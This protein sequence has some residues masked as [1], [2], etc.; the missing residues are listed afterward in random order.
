MAAPRVITRAPTAPVLTD[1][2]RERLSQPLDDERE[3]VLTNLARRSRTVSPLV[4]GAAFFSLLAAAERPVRADDVTLKNGTVMQNVLVVETPD[5]PHTL[6]V[7]TAPAAW[8]EYNKDDVE[9][10]DKKPAILASKQVTVP[11]G[12]ATIETTK[13]GADLSFP[14]QAEAKLP[15]DAVV[16]VPDAGGAVTLTGKASVRVPADS[17]VGLPKG[18]S[19]Q[20]ANGVVADLPADATVPMGPQDTA[21][22][23]PTDKPATVTF[24]GKGNVTTEAGGTVTVPANAGVKVPG[25]ARVSLPESVKVTPYTELQPAPEAAP[26]PAA[27]APAPWTAPADVSIRMPPNG[28]TVTLPNAGKVT[29]P[30]NSVITVPAGGAQLTVPPNS[31]LKV[32]KASTL[33]LPKNSGVRYGSGLWEEVEADADVAVDEGDTVRLPAKDTQ[34]QLP[35]GTRVTTHKSAAEMDLPAATQIGVRG[36]AQM[37][38]PKDAVVT[39]NAAPAAP[40]AAPAPDA[41]TAPAAP[42]GATTAPPTPALVYAEVD[43]MLGPGLDGTYHGNVGAAIGKLTKALKGNKELAKDAQFWLRLGML[44]GSQGQTYYGQPPTRSDSVRTSRSLAMGCLNTALELDPNVRNSSLR[45]HPFTEWYDGI[46]NTLRMFP[47][48]DIEALRVGVR[49]DGSVGLRR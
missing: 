3:G 31:Q 34:I 45:G 25:P 17:Q 23:R 24:T 2:E 12:G 32:P 37:P 43:G 10:V 7:Y 41:G 42:T 28:A 49:P 11:A 38:V 15:K 1:L 8:A 40:T 14:A 16:T 36:S 47:V 21:T 44:Y 27:A 19:I 46:G 9:K 4:V 26:A 20:Y 39:P 48:S 5:K 13:F 18:A 35:E 29:V 22:L 30:G 33:R 6:R